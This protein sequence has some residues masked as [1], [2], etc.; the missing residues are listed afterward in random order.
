VGVGHK[1]VQIR[2]QPEA[3]KVCRVALPVVAVA[4]VVAEK[5]PAGHVA[6]AVAVAAAAAI[7]NFASPHIRSSHTRQTVRVEG[8]AARVLGQAQAQV[9]MATAD[10]TPAELEADLR[11]LQ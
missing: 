6:V 3:G 10:C 9:P 5:A 8:A 11:P 4:V 1:A 7:G 2:Q